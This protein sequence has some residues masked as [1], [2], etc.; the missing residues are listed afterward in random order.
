M[1]ISL[2]FEQNDQFFVD[3]YNNS[4]LSG[5]LLDNLLCHILK[6]LLR[7]YKFNLIRFGILARKGVKDLNSL[8]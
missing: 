1:T 7:V 5:I 2:E 6:L 4:Y 3:K 8:C